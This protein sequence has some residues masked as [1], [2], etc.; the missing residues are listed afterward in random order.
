MRMPF[1]ERFD[2]KDA[3]HCLAPTNW[4]YLFLD[5][6]THVFK[7][8]LDKLMAVNVQQGEEKFNRRKALR[9]IVVK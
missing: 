1:G 5:G 2:K 6:F 7:S 8:N 3:F 9:A 4:E